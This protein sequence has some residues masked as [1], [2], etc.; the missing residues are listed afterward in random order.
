MLLFFS[1]FSKFCISFN[2]LLNKKMRK[3]NVRQIYLHCAF[4][5]IYLEDLNISKHPMEPKVME[6]IHSKVKV[7]KFVHILALVTLSVYLYVAGHYM[8]K[9]R[10][11]KVVD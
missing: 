8:R 4:Q 2:I 9:R 5:F 11:P 1:L 10:G 7:V 3:D 6:C